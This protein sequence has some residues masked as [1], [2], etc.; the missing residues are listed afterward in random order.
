MG[1]S[2]RNRLCQEKLS[3]PICGGS[4]LRN[5]KNVFDL[6]ACLGNVPKAATVDEAVDLGHID[7]HR[8]G[9][10]VGGSAIRRSC[11]YEVKDL[12]PIPVA[13]WVGWDRLGG[14]G[15]EPATGDGPAVFKGSSLVAS[16]R[17]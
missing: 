17:L 8:L 10:L 16:P 11:L 13:F 5:D 15:A 7:A 1:T 4:D 12:L 14:T 9:H 2:S 6:Q 3:R